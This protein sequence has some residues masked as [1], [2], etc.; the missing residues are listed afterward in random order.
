LWSKGG[1]AK[2][3]GSAPGG[4]RLAK[5]RAVQPLLCVAKGDQAATRCPTRSQA[6]IFGRSNPS[7]EGTLVSPIQSVPQ[8]LAPG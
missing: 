6:L 3:A 4:G 2:P 8:A 7:G 1:G 5:D